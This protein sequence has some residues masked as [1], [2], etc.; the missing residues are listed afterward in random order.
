MV[1]FACFSPH[2]PILLPDVGSL[3]DRTIAHKTISALES[4]GNKLKEAKP[5]QIIISSPHQDWGFNVPLFFLAKDFK[6][7]V[8]HYLTGSESPTFHFNKGKEIYG[9]AEYKIQDTKYKVALVAS[10]DTS[11]CLKPE[12]PYG[13]NPDG[14]KFDAELRKCLEKKNIDRILT[15]EEKYPEAADCGLRSFCFLLGVLEAAKIKWQSEI[16]SYEGPWGVGYLVVNFHHATPG[17]QV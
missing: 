14:P 16:L 10:G 3:Q 4:L 6:G 13:F 7:K 12:G 9:D 1:V 11:H 17:L 5:D 15:L 2:A 8:N